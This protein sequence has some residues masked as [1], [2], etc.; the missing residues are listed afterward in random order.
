MQTW[1]IDFQG[2]DGSRRL[3]AA[4][5]ERIAELARHHEAIATCQV[6][7]KG[8]QAGKRSGLHLV[9]IHLTLIDGRE[10]NIGRS[11]RIDKRY[12]ELDFAIN[13]TFRRARRRLKDHLSG[14]PGEISRESGTPAPAPTPGAD[15]AVPVTA[16]AQSGPASADAAVEATSS[17]PEAGSPIEPPTAMVSDAVPNQGA[18][19]PD[20]SPA[21]LAS[22]TAATVADEPALA[23]EPTVEPPAEPTAE[24]AAETASAEAMAA[25]A[26]AP[27]QATNLSPLFMALAVGTALTAAATLNASAIWAR[28]F[29]DAAEGKGNTDADIGESGEAPS[30]T[31]GGR[32]ARSD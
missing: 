19:T 25:A 16:G 22:E 32:P 28:L 6:V 20:I 1:M 17:P 30:G 15:P 29:K 3:R 21:P 14:R 2:I 27:E 8:P 13:D 31:G 7:A 24:P 5:E 18:A 12:A 11:P 9:D 4:I 23:A 26:V 10:L